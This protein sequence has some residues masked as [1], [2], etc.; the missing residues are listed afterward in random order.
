MSHERP[1]GL[2]RNDE[3]DIRVLLG[4]ATTGAYV[5]LAVLLVRGQWN[6]EWWTALAA[7]GSVT[8]GIV[9]AWAVLI[10]LKQI[11]S[12]E[13]IASDETHETI[14]RHSLQLAREIRET[15]LEL[16]QHALA[17]DRTLARVLSTESTRPAHETLENFHREALRSYQTSLDS[18]ERNIQQL[19]AALSTLRVVIEQVD[20]RYASSRV[21]VIH[22]CMRLWEP[23]DS[24]LFALR[25][26][27]AA[28]HSRRVVLLIDRCEREFER[29]VSQPV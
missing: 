5:I 3:E 2:K 19:D 18:T 9:V 29:S 24:D 25:V 23:L 20:G 11:G 6:S 8:Q 16:K 10:A 12:Q 22:R 21:A 17:I 15:S 26:T 7:I 13:K 14:L 27:A 4:V 28:D 1:P